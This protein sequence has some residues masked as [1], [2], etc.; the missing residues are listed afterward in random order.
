MLLIGLGLGGETEPE[1]NQYTRVV[2]E[3]I[4]IRVP[5][6][7]GQAASGN[8]PVPAATPVT[9]WREGRGPRCLRARAIAG[10]RVRGRN[11]VDLILKNERRFRAKLADNCPALDYYYGFYINP[12]PD[13]MVCADR[14]IIRSR[15]GG[16]CAIHAFRSLQ[17]VRQVVQRR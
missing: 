15:M 2:R 13:G 17:A 16:Q 3:R 4:I 9:R 6:R 12:N 11:S 14:D 1:S 8:A 5:A 10:A 7:A